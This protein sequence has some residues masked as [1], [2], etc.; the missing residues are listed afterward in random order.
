MAGNDQRQGADDPMSP[1]GADADSVGPS[2]RRKA[3]DRRVAAVLLVCLS[4]VAAWQTASSFASRDSGGFELSA[5]DFEGFKPSPDGWGVERL[6]AGGD[7]LEP[8]VL[9]YRMTPLDPQKG[10]GVMVRLVH[11]YNTRDCMRIKGYDV[12]LTGDVPDKP[13]S[14]IPSISGRLQTWRLVS[15]EGRI[16]IWCTRMVRAYDF[17]PTSDSVT[18]MAFPKV[19]IPDDPNW[20]PRGLTLESLR[21][22]V[23]NFRLF[24]RSKWNSSR[25]DPLTFLGLKRPAWA[26]DKAFTIVGMSYDDGSILPEDENRA[27]A[28]VAEAMD[29]ILA[30]LHR[31]RMSS[32]PTLPV[33]G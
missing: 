22:P 33:S 2:A 16:S 15:G 31:W 4:A 25:C 28:T 6:P 9:V 21:H 7:P 1:D 29:A 12:I 10:H 13:V 3:E 30:E 19:G 26:S 20:V 23:R 8:N 11:G 5:A 27:A 17:A 18:S 32:P 24:L 14:A